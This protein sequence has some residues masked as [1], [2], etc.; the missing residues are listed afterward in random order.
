VNGPNREMGGF[1][2]SAERKEND[3]RRG[4]QLR[5]RKSYISV[6]KPKESKAIGKGGR[7]TRRKRIRPACDPLVRPVKEKR[8]TQTRGGGTQTF[9]SSLPICWGDAH[10]QKKKRSK[11]WRMSSNKEARSNYIKVEDQ[12]RDRACSE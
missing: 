10:L 12:I 11:A 4:K 2:K 7:T 9:K 8:S 5:T 6:E 3:K 1:D